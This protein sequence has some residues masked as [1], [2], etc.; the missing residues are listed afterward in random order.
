MTS[1][2]PTI[3]DDKSKE[4]G[5]INVRKSNLIWS[6]GETKVLFQKFRLWPTFVGTRDDPEKFGGTLGA[7]VLPVHLWPEQ[8][9]VLQDQQ[10]KDKN[11]GN[12][13]NSSDNERK[14]KRKRNDDEDEQEIDNSES[15]TS[16]KDDIS[17]GLRKKSK[18]SSSGVFSVVSS[19]LSWAWEYIKFPFSSS[20][21]SSLNSSNVSLSE[22]LSRSSS[23]SSSSIVPDHPLTNAELQQLVFEDLQKRG[24]FIGPGDVYGG[25]YNIYKVSYSL[26]MFTF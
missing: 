21:S 2:L 4:N 10:I 25:D 20:S 11:N 26:Y 6:E 13:S 5:P 24:Y 9:K 19:T 14:K 16:I 1:T 17:G 22:S 12:N 8:A 18:S 7:S 15:E 23:S 3:S